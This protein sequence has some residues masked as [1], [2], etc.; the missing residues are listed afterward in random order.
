VTQRRVRIRKVVRPRPRDPIA[1]TVDP[2]DPTIVRAKEH[3]YATGRSR[4]A[5]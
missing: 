4:R 3:L 2:R 5:A 1:T